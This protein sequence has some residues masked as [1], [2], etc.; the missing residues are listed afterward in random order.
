[1]CPKATNVL[2]EFARWACAPHLFDLGVG[3]GGGVGWGGA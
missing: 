2:E 3:A 1:M